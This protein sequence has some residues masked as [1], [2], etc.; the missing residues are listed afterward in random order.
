MKKRNSS[1]W[2]L[3]GILLIVAVSVFFTFVIIMHMTQKQAAEMPWVTDSEDADAEVVLENVYITSSSGGTISFLYE[4]QTYALAGNLAEDYTGIADIRIRKQEI[5]EIDV[6]KEYIE[7][8]L[9]GYLEQEIKIEGYGWVECAPGYALYSDYGQEIRGITLSDLIVGSSELKYYIADGKISAIVQ[10]VET[11]ATE[12]GVLIKNGADVAYSSLYFICEQNWYIDGE[13]QPA[14]EIFDAVSYMRQKNAEEILLTWDGVSMYL[15]DAQGKYLSEAYEGT[16]S[17][18]LYDRNTGIDAGLVLVNTVS[19]ETYVAYV[20]P[21]EMPE[22]F[23]Y[24]ALKAQAVCARTYAC[25][26]MTD[27]KYAAFGANLDDTTA[28]QAYNDKGR[29][30][31]C[32]QAATDTRGQIL[33]FEGERIDC[34]Y[35][36]TSPGVTENLEVWEKDSPAYL[37]VRNFTEKEYGDLSNA[38]NFLSYIQ[39]TPD[40]YDSASPFYRWHA[41][42]DLSGGSDPTFGTLKR[43][44]VSDRTSAGYVCGLTV[45]FEY[46]SVLLENENEIR[47]FLGTYLKELTLSDGSTRDNFT[48]LPSA[49]FAITENDGST[50][51][52]TGGG[53]GHGIGMSQYGA[54]AMGQEGMDYTA[55]LSAYFPGTEISQLEL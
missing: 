8:T 25:D 13:A 53:F 45:S 34:Y 4:G 32:D 55:I 51:Y 31:L 41:V 12:I 46:G 10:S 52:L 35:Y 39:A 38:A 20:L 28:Y 19:L 14:G 22:S 24:E 33:T 6:K 15:C 36:S 7:G 1:R 18:Q 23:S 54:N 17:V 47:Q 26:Q 42:L 27:G 40:S 2:L 5:Y 3:I 37:T 49:C 43:V 11:T 50:L 30:E 16:F 29:T 9:L 44:S 21:S 48:T